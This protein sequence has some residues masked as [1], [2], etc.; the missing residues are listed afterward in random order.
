[1]KLRFFHSSVFFYVSMLTWDFFF[2]QKLLAAYFCDACILVEY[3]KWTHSAKQEHFSVA[4][5]G[6]IRAV[7][8]NW[9]T[10]SNCSVC[11]LSHSLYFFMLGKT[12]RDTVTSCAQK[13][14]LLTA[15]SSEVTTSCR[16]IQNAT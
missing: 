12:T 2:L 5:T 15:G 11:L 3:C 14:I 1:M 8:H 7:S 16:P 6:C 4:T 13:V 10:E 9:G